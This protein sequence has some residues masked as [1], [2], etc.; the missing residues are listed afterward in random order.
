MLELDEHIRVLQATIEKQGD[1]INGIADYIYTCFANGNKLLIAGNGGSAADAQ[2]MAA[3]FVNK[4]GK[5]RRALPAIA[6]TTDTSVITSISNDSSFDYV[7]SRQ[8]QALG[9]PGDVLLCITTSGS[10]NI[11]QALREAKGLASICLTGLTGRSR[12]RGKCDLM[13]VV[14]STNTAR[15]QECHEFILHLICG[16]V[17]ERL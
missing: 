1:I 15:I 2:H 3:E 9:Q 6:L 13:L 11:I 17:E 8:I 5:Q 16:K 7:F 4:F 14:P 12:L 10:K